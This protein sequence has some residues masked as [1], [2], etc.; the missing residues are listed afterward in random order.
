MIFLFSCQ[1][2]AV[3]RNP[4]SFSFEFDPSRSC[5]DIDIVLED[6]NTH[7]DYKYDKNELSTWLESRGATKA[8][9]LVAHGLNLKP[10]KMNALA[11]VLTSNGTEVLRVSLAGHRGSKKEGLFTT[12]QTWRNEFQAHYCLAKK[13]AQ[14][15]NVPLYF[16]GFSLGALAGVDFLNTQVSHLVEKMVLISPATDVHWYSKI[17]GNLGWIGGR[18]S[19]P[20]KNIKAYRSQPSTSLASYRAMKESQES[21]DEISLSSL[22]IPTMIFVDPDDELVSLKKINKRINKQRLDNWKTKS[23]NNSGST[24]KKTY[25]HLVVDKASMGSHQWEIVKKNIIDHFNLKE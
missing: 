10:S 8:I 20:S 17:P 23:I 5:A 16:L 7:S 25:H 3:E 6:L 15:L 12:H 9:A 13:R 11:K 1:N 19:L 14:S 18:I 2:M 4:N 22:N 21:L 24:L